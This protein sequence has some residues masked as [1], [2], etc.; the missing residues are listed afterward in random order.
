MRNYRR[1]YKAKKKKSILKNRIFWLSILVLTVFSGVF[2]L[3]LF[4]S[5]FQIKTVEIFGNKAEELEDLV[6]NKSSRQ[7]LFF[8]S[9]SIFLADFAEINREILNS[10]P[11][12][13]QA[14]LRRKLPDTLH[15]HIKEREAA[16]VFT[17][18]DKSFLIDKEGIIFDFYDPGAKEQ[19]F[20]KIRRPDEKEVGLKD[21]VITEDQLSKILEA[22]SKLKKELNILAEDIIAI[23][24]V[25]YDIKTPE[26][27]QIYFNFQEDL[28]WQL[29]KLKA[30]LEED[31]PPDKRKNLR[32]IDVRF[33]SFAVPVLINQ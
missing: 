27:F 25:R 11:H 18:S 8:S 32:Y 33:G 2:Y 14:S 31:Y 3:I 4:H 12:I 30:L 21:K 7:I 5:F 20:I 13:S 6:R 24:E 23:S 22:E 9:R 19:N 1:P 28:G 15:L 26:G 29:T 10:F 16:A 17:Q